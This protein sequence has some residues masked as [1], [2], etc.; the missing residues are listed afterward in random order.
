[1]SDDDPRPPVGARFHRSAAGPGPADAEPGPTPFP[2]VLRGYDRARVEERF[3]EL[4]AEVVALREEVRRLRA[5]QAEVVRAAGS[6][7][8]TDGSGTEP[9][10]VEGL[11]VEDKIARMTRH[12]AARLR[13]TALTDAARPRVRD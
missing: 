10:E 3:R 12:E 13:V 6:R 4:E 8:G 1:V 9:P 11:D 7:S 2:L 5:E